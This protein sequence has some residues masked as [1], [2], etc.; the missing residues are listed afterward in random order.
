[1]FLCST[2]SSHCHKKIC[3]NLYVSKLV[4]LNSC[5]RNLVVSLPYA[6]VFFISECC[7]CCLVQL[8]LGRDDYIIISWEKIWNYIFFRFN[9]KSQHSASVIIAEHMLFMCANYS[10]YEAAHAEFSRVDI[11]FNYIVWW[12]QLPVPIL[13][14]FL[15]LNFTPKHI[16]SMNRMFSAR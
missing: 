11:S 13:I 1:M 8:V 14:L 7:C 9:V 5:D 16:W 2:N 3:L 12:L 6:I 15:E 10:R 4:L